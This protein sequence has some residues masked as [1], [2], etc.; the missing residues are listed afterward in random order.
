[1]PLTA[2]G[3][4]GA[5]ARFVT[6]REMFRHRPATVS[7]QKIGISAVKDL[8]ECVAMT[9]DAGIIRGSLEVDVGMG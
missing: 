9:V 1:M 5:F 2:Q 7:P 6:R 8:R 4:G 3:E